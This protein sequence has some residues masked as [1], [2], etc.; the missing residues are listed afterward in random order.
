MGVISSKFT[1][2][3]EAERGG[4]WDL[5]A[6]ILGFAKPQVSGTQRDVVL[7]PQCCLVAQPLPPLL[8]HLELSVAMCHSSGPL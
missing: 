8:C 1:G 3:G 6:S 7:S 5:A 4:Q 2:W